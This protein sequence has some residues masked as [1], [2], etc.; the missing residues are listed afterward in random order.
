MNEQIMDNVSANG[1]RKIV[2]FTPQT[3][4]QTDLCLIIGDFWIILP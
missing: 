2:N 3:A 1:T 4:R